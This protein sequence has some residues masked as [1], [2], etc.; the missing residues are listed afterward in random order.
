MDELII[1]LRERNIPETT[2][3]R[4]EEDKIDVSVLLL[5]T[6][7]QMKSYFPS[8]GDRL[9]VMGFCRRQEREPGKRTCRKSKLFERL[10]SKLTK[11]QKPDN[12]Q[13]ETQNTTKKHSQRIVRK[14]EMG[15]MHHDGQGFVQMRAK[16]GGG[17]RKLS[18]PKEWKRKELIEEAICL[19]FPNGKNSHGSISEFE[20]DLTNYQEV[21]LDAESTVGEMYNAS[22]LTMMRFYL[23]TKK[24]EKEVETE[25]EEEMSDQMEDF[26]SNNQDQSLPSTSS[27]MNDFFP[28]E[29]D[30][31]YVDSPVNDTASPFHSTEDHVAEDDLNVSFQSSLVTL[32]DYLDSSNVVTVLTGDIIGIDE[33]NLDDTLPLS[34]EPIAPQTKILVVHRGQIFSELI[35]HFCDETLTH[36]QS[37]VEVKLLLPNG[38][39]EMGHDVGGVFRDCLSEF[40][41]EFYDQCTLGNSFKVPFLRHDF[42]KE[43]WESV[44]RIIL[45]GWKKEKYLP[46]KLAPVILQQAIQGSVKSD[47]IENFLKYVSENECAVLESCRTDF[48]SADQ[49]ELLETL[50][51]YSCRKIPTDENFKQILEELAHKTLIQEPAYVLEQWAGILGPLRKDLEEI[52][53]VYCALQP[54]VRKIVQSLKFPETMNVQQKD[55]TK[56]L[57]T[58]LREC[59]AKRQSLFLRFCTGSDLFIGKAITVDFTDLKGFE[60]RPVAHTCGCFLRL[61]VHYDNYPDFR[62]EMNKVL[63]S[64][65]WVMD[66]V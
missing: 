6:D 47:L 29:M 65:I 50:D 46:I 1:L 40:W 14:I 9:A 63:E 17:T 66:I 51:N 20:L 5:M 18:V 3:K 60:R 37:E 32:P 44:A 57:T 8:Y 41:Q 38:Q 7:D 58:Y 28:S 12:S 53:D 11:R 23:T 36:T 54:T 59:D 48:C 35:A 42:G 15:W 26:H 31:I 39:F 62:S 13:T 16:K 21:S 24:V 33:Q 2:I 4:L 56:H 45:F 55:I 49:E 34:P 22:K 25:S 19:F 30:V 10:K 52:E 64:N 43:K 61:S 27:G